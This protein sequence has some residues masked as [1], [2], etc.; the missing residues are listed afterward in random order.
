M[1]IET[2]SLTLSLLLAAA[3][4]AAEPVVQPAADPAAQP[5]AVLTEVQPWALSPAD[6]VEITR[7]LD[8]AVKH[9]FPDA[10]GA[11][12]FQGELKV[13]GLKD[14]SH[15][16]RSYSINGRR[17]RSST[18]V[19]D[20]VTTISGLHLKLS[21]G[22][23]LA[24]LSQLLPAAGVDAA[25]ATPVALGD[26][27]ETAR[28]LAHEAMPE[29]AER[30]VEQ[31]LEHFP[32]A[33]RPA[34]RAGMA[35][36]PL[37]AVVGG[38]DPT[39]MPPVVLHLI[40]LGVP[41][42]GSGLVMIAATQS[43]MRRFQGSD[44]PQPLLL[45]TADSERYQRQQ[46][47][48]MQG[49]MR[50]AGAKGAGHELELK[51]DKLPA[52]VAQTLSEWFRAGLVTPTTELPADRALAGLE[53]MLGADTPPDLREQARLFAARAALPATRPADASFALR[54][55][56]WDRP[57]PRMGMV[58]DED[59]T[60]P[61]M[62]DEQLAQLPEQYREQLR[63]AKEAKANRFTLSD[64]GA[65]IALTSDTGGS[66]WLD[67]EN[68]WMSRGT[69][70]P[71]TVGENALRIIASLLH[72]DPRVLIGRNPL[73]PWTRV[74][75]LE[76]A[77][78]LQAWW[79][80][81]AQQ[82]LATIFTGVIPALDA[83]AAGRLIQAM[84]E[85]ERAPLIAALVAHWRAHPPL[86]ATADELAEALVALPEDPAV[87]EVV[88]ALPVTGVQRL[89]LAT[90][91]SRHGEERHLDLLLEESLTAASHP[92]EDED[93]DAGEDSAVFAIVMRQ[94]S[95]ARVSRLMA[96]LGGGLDQPATQR[97]LAVGFNFGWTQN[98]AMTLIEGTQRR[99]SGNGDE[100]V[101]RVLQLALLGD[102]RPV[103]AGM[104]KVMDDHVL[105]TLGKSNVYLSGGR[106]ESGADAKPL[107]LPA[108]LRIC[109][110]AAF[111]AVG[112]SWMWG[113]RDDSGN[114]PAFDLTQP[115]A[116]REAVLN[117]LR[118]RSRETATKALSAAKLPLTL[119]PKAGLPTG[120]T[121]EKALF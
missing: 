114:T 83:G 84:P 90:W 11:S 88:R 92:G 106:E 60:G 30:D 7:L 13:T 121:D 66:R 93:D 44:E 32:A 80:E 9:G 112:N 67:G 57:D 110:L 69:Q 61:E 35:W 17:V 97:I 117:D 64:L 86:T 116:A 48:R 37:F 12:V 52:T 119:L 120:G 96:G 103:P 65:L 72:A 77:T 98:P 104:T 118:E 100:A 58:S 34:L 39:T 102:I 99:R 22:R 19:K 55:A 24:N 14:G 82:P 94:P 62:T 31:G 23:W 49:R 50:Q 3:L 63:K 89:V 33:Q 28:K 85:A 15:I 29:M 18:Q 95:V 108:D 113:L 10:A 111:S 56:L 81:H 78:A 6:Q 101:R 54:V 36:M 4:Q 76:T 2:R 46:M 42:A 91:H 45:S 53:A 70:T 87:A 115:L 16:S 51:L 27:L 105:L 68:N 107:V 20:G 21:D 25:A 40:R 8:A 79:K 47:E 74:A 75:Q 43:G 59:D 109:D 41:G 26:F 38:M 73:E 1:L 5:T 71:R